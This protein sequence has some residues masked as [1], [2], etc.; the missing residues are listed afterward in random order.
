MRLDS[1][2]IAF[3]NPNEDIVERYEL[4]IQ[5]YVEN[6]DSFGVMP[7]NGKC[8]VNIDCSTSTYKIRLTDFNGY[9]MFIP[10]DSD[11]NLEYLKKLQEDK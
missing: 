4:P 6:E 1:Y 11:Y 2:K 7:V 8:I 9:K 5:D 10:V 3:A